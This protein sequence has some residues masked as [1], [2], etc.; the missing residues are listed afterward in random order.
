MGTKPVQMTWLE[1][2]VTH[3]PYLLACQSQNL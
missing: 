2:F 1:A 3:Q